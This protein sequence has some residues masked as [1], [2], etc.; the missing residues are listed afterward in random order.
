MATTKKEISLVVDADNGN[1][2]PGNGD[3]AK[4]DTAGTALTVNSRRFLADRRASTQRIDQNFK[5]LR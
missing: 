3:M 2:D 4:G 5:N 1:S